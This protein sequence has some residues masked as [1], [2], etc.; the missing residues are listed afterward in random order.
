[1]DLNF[2]NKEIVS[3]NL[4]DCYSDKFST[5]K[6]LEKIPKISPYLCSYEV[7]QLALITSNVIV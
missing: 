7:I 5:R 4:Q 2:K 6:H 3:I 1:M